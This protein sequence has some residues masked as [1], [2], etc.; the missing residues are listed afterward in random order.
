MTYHTHKN[1][2]SPVSKPLLLTAAIVYSL[3]LQANAATFA[4]ISSPGDGLISSIALT[5]TTA[6]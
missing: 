4:Y 6:R 1:K 3:S 5:R 2:G